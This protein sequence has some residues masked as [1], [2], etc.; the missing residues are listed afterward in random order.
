MASTRGHTSP[1]GE[2]WPDHS[3]MLGFPLLYFKPS[4]LAVLD[5]VMTRSSENIAL[6]TG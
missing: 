3:L 6:P 4:V 5:A 1:P 2:S